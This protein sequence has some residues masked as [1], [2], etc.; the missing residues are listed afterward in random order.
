MTQADVAAQIAAGMKIELASL[1][2]AL[3]K[4]AKQLGW[5]IGITAKAGQAKYGLDAPLAAYLLKETEIPNG[6]THH[7]RAGATAD[8]RVE[9]EI[10]LRFGQDVPAGSSPDAV[11]AAIAGMGPAIELIDMNKPGEPLETL[12]SHCIWHE[13]VLFGAEFEPKRWLGSDYAPGPKVILN[14]E[15]ARTPDAALVPADLGAL[16]AHVSQYLARC[17]RMLRKDERVICGSFT[18]PLP[19]KPGDR[20]TVDFG[21]VGHVSVTLA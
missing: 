5:K 12:L 10:F 3:A 19:I 8:I 4:G 15:E 17:G 20:V 18:V 14:G 2:A 11:R 21:S 7:A 13:A 9:A 6:A 16:A 1:D